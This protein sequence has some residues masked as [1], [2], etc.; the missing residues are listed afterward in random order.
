[1]APFKVNDTL[2]YAF[3]A[4]H[5]ETLPCGKCARLQFNDKWSYDTSPW[6]THLALK[7]KILIVMANNTGTIGKNQFDIMIP[8]G[9]TGAFNCLSEQIGSNSSDLGRRDGGVLAECVFDGPG[10]SNRF[11]LEQWQQCVTE[12]CHRAFDGKPK[13][14][15][16]GCLWQSSWLMAADNPE[17]YWTEVACPKALV[18]KYNST[19]Y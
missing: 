14:L 2:A 16:D 19:Q 3:A 10:P 1:M 6:V 17:V 11:T 15:L 7:G 8:G 13:E 5:E 4:T 9:G 18:E 12:K